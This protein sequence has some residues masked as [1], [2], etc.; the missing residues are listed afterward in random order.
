MRTIAQTPP[1]PR[2]I[3]MRRTTCL[4]A[5]LAATI[6]VIA[7]DDAT[8]PELSDLD[9]MRQGTERYHS[10]QAAVADGFI[11]L[12]PCVA[13]PAGGMGIHYGHPDRIGNGAVDP[14]APEILLYEPIAGGGMSLVGVE[15]M[16]HGEAWHAAGNGAPPAVAGQPFDAPNP[17]HP[18]EHVRPFYTLHVWL[19][20]DNPAGMF[21]AFNPAV[22]CGDQAGSH[23]AH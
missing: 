4:A 12:S 15:F 7:C 20:K 13:S 17:N 8:T 21:A 3:T 16:V 19:W 5:A 1:N 11:A 18:D 23:G 6:T 14:A 2:R 10:I 22:S 9:L